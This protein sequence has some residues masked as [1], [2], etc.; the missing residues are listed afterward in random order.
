MD[1]TGIR[2]TTDYDDIDDLESISKELEKIADP[3]LDNLENESENLPSV[4][5]SDQLLAD[6]YQKRRPQKPNPQTVKGKN[7]SYAISDGSI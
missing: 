4:H 6:E 7:K 1:F 2:K 3:L 5:D